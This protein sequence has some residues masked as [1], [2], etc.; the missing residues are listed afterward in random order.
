MASFAGLSRPED[1]LV[2]EMA[3][4]EAENSFE[5]LD[6][7][8][9]PAVLDTMLSAL[10]GRLNTDGESRPLDEKSSLGVTPGDEGC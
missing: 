6:T 2:D 5:L 9:P 10:A 1:D 8:E 3:E 4:V 7:V